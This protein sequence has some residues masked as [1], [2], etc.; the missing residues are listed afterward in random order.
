MVL[1]GV[2]GAVFCC[3]MGL[4]CCWWTGTDWPRTDRL[5]SESRDIVDIWWA[6]KFFSAMLPLPI[7]DKCVLSR[8]DLKFL[9]TYWLAIPPC[10]VH[11]SW[12]GES[13]AWRFV[14]IT[15]AENCCP[16][17]G[18]SLWNWKIV[19]TVASDQQFRDSA[20]FYLSVEISNS[21][22]SILNWL[23]FKTNLSILNQF[24]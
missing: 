16:V 19:E 8:C 20:R 7:Y 6:K 5:E 21:F 13:K 3:W 9:I 22:S 4:E 15:S 10:W 17:G 2:D 24:F 23:I 12:L 18:E 1:R 14:V 11:R